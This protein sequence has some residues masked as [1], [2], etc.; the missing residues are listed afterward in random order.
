MKDLPNHTNKC[1]LFCNQI[2]NSSYNDNMKRYI[3]LDIDG[4][5]ATT[6]Q[7]YSKNF[8]E[9]NTY[10]FDKKCVKVLN[11]I[12]DETKA[13]IILS[14]DWKYNYDFET[15]NE[16]FGWNGINTEITDFTP[17]LWGVRYFKLQELEACRTEE[18][19]KYATKHNME[20][21][22]AIDD[23]DMSKMLPEENFVLTPRANEGI[24]QSGIKHKI[25]KKL[26]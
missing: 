19:I 9:W 1:N 2:K 22:V 8:N 15:M 20:K 14:S 17:S 26:L 23:L 6:R 5:L 11:E 10:N 25:L 3:F 18:I 7:F 13:I 21:W 12:L 4:V 16:I 24:K